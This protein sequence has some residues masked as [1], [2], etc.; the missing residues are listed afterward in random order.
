MKIPFI[1]PSTKDLGYSHVLS[2]AVEEKYTAIVSSQT[3]NIAVSSGSAAAYMIF[4]RIYDI[5][6]PCT[7]LAP[8]LTFPSPVWAAIQCGHKIVFV[9]VDDS[10][11]M[12]YTDYLQKRQLA[13]CGKLV[14]M[15]TLYGGVSRLGA[16][17]EHFNYHDE[18]MVV[19]A[20]HCVDIAVPFNYAFTSFHKQKPIVASHGGML[21]CMLE[22]DR[23]YF[24][25]F[26]DFG[27]H[28]NGAVIQDGFRFYLDAPNCELALTS[29]NNVRHNINA[30]KSIFNLYR[31][32]TNQLVQHDS[33]S[34]YNLATL[35]VSNREMYNKLIKLMYLGY[36]YLPL[37]HS[38]YFQ[39]CIIGD[40]P[41]TNAFDGKYVN[42]PVHTELTI[43][44]VSTIVEVLKGY[45]WDQRARE[46]RKIG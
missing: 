19:D 41:N 14:V 17:W 6:G 20:A 18:I 45:C 15:P 32:V 22:S 43:Q 35:F 13:G 12:S 5:H 9:D 33:N 44:D 8:S 16:G 46:W 24:E 2:M 37:H 4:K 21:L 27:R 31:Q 29:M 3:Y 7:V 10:L 28:S 1:P 38:S 25:K 39:H 42:L 40:L 34:S 11:C 23:H 36:N 26:K 30:R